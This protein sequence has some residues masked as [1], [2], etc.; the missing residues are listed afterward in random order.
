MKLREVMGCIQVEV[1]FG[2]VIAHVWFIEFQ[3]R[4]LPNAHC[5][6]FLD[7]A[8]K[9][10]LKEPEYVDTTISANI[11]SKSNPDLR[12]VVPKH[13]IHDPCGEL[14]SFALCTVK[15]DEEDSPD[16]CSKYFLKLTKEETKHSD[17]AYYVNYKRRDRFNGGEY[18]IQKFRYNWGSFER[19][20]DNV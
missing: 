15:D 4:G 17:T 11:P 12:K 10:K 8:F 20:M 14:K 9:D 7:K 16:F 18:A 5:T 1:K 2:K 19:I 3:K 6:S 13:S